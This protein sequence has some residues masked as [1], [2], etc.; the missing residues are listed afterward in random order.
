METPVCVNLN[1]FIERSNGIFGKSGTGKSF[2]NRIFLR[3]HLQIW[4]QSWSLTCTTNT[5]G[6]PM[7][8]KAKAHPE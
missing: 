4:P 6:R 1:R 8:R 2:L 3:H 5:A 7:S